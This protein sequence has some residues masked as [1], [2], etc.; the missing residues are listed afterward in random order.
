MLVA[1]GWDRDEA[2]AFVAN[3]PHTAIVELDVEDDGDGEL[4]P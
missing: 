1:R 3:T 4:R 2:R